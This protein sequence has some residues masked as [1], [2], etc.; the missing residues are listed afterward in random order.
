MLIRSVRRILTMTGWPTSVIL[1]LLLLVMFAVQPAAANT[2]SFVMPV[3]ALQA[4]LTASL[5]PG[6]DANLFGFYDL[7]I[8]P[9]VTAD[10]CDDE[11]VPCTNM[12][13]IIDFSS[14]EEGSE[15]PIPSGAD[16]W[17]AGSATTDPGG[18]LCATALPCFHFTFDPLDTYLA[19][20][21]PNANVVGKMFDGRTGEQMPGNASFVMYVDSPTPITLGTPIRFEFFANAYEFKDLAVS[22]DNT[23]KVGYSGYID[24]DAEL[25]EPMPALT[26]GGGLLLLFVLAGMRRVRKTS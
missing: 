7:Y 1:G 15:S 16:R 18:E 8:R 25:P 4:R 19:L 3:S 22:G 14:T 11:S 10:G 24:V 2:Y 23:K 20:I 12:G 9:K 6:Q 26:G 21:T 5:N 17:S 13:N